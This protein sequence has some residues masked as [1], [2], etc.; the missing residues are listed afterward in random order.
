MLG[1]LIQWLCGMHKTK[2]IDV[3]IRERYEE[4]GTVNRGSRA[5]GECGERVV[6]I[7]YAHW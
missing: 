1:D 7:Q 3:S 2:Q 6:I 4:K 5:M